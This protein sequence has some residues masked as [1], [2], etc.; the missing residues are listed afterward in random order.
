MSLFVTFEGIEGCGKSYQSRILYKRLLKS[1]TPVILTVEPGGTPLGDAVRNLLKK[2]RFPISPA[3][4]L[5]LFNASRS[6]HVKDVIKPALEAKKVIICDRYTDSTVVYQGYGRG[7]DI[8]QVKQINSIGAQGIMP[9]ITFLL[10]LPVQSGLERKKNRHNDRFDAEEIAFHERIRR[11]FLDL[12]ARNNKRWLVI[13]G[14]QSRKRISE[15][16][17]N[18]IESVL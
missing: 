13:D 11:G 1:G 15:I 12:A 10:D 5:F 2:S 3:A 4:E 17:W 7:L 18:K 14:L 9:D 16:I 6:Q 8:T